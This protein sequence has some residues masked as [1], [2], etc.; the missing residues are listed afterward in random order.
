MSRFLWFTVYITVTAEALVSRRVPA[1][2]PYDVLGVCR[3]AALETAAAQEGVSAVVDAQ[4]V[5][6][7]TA[8]VCGSTKC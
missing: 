5:Q 7:C 4:P 1:G 2:F 3:S 8:E 6:Q